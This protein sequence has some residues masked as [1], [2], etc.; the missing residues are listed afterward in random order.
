VPAGAHDVVLPD[1]HQPERAIRI[2]LA[3]GLSA[4][5]NAER[6]FV[7]ARRIAR[8]RIQIAQRLEEARLRRG[9]AEQRLRRIEGAR[10]L[11]DLSGATPASRGVRAAAS[12][13]AGPR[14]YLTSRGLSVHVGRGA[15][16]NHRLTFE[17]ARPEDLWFHARDTPGAHVILRDDQGRANDDDR[18]EAAELAAFFS[19]AAAA[20]AVDVHCARRKHLRPGKGGAGRVLVGHSETLRVAPKDPEGRLRRR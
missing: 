19:D 3:A 15:K 16:E 10:F 2:E 1:P 4:V 20:A 18:R 8:G 5:A 6:L 17:R 7:K 11:A 12:P 9:V 14:H 13:P